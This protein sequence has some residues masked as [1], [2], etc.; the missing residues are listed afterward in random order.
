MP[1]FHDGDE[2][3]WLRARS[4]TPAPPPPFEDPP[5][6]PLFVPEAEDGSHKRAPRPPRPA[7]AQHRAEYWPWDTSTGAGSGSGHLPVV[8]QGKLPGRRWM[9]LAWAI[10]GLALV[11]LAVVAAYQLGGGGVGEN[12]NGNDAGP[13]PDATQTVLEPIADVTPR[14]FDPLGNPPEENPDQVPNTVDGDPGTTWRTMTYNDQLAPDGYKA[15]VGLLLDLGEVREVGQL[16]VRV[17][18]GVTTASIFVTEE[19]L[20][21]FEGVQQADPVGEV[22]GDGELELGLDD[23]VEGRYVTIWFTALPQV[24]DGFRG[25]VAEVVVLG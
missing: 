14:D 20:S 8:G 6:R 24:A 19:E 23:P 2:V 22:S 3:E 16:Q 7:P 13:P 11:L 5:E 18:G 9:R 4:Q 1:V 10:G 21:G 25:E 17:V 15:G 12:G